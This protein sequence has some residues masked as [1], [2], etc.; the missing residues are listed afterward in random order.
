MNTLN[1]S[2]EHQSLPR[3]IAITGQEGSG[4]DSLGDFFAN[5]GYMHVSAGDVLRERARGLGHADPIPRT[6][7][8]QVGD[9]LKKEFG[10]SP[11]TESTLAKYE[12]SREEFPAGL[13]ISGLRRVG[14]LKAFK[15]HGA[16]SIWIDADEE[17]RF[18]HINNRSRGDEQAR[19]DFA[20]KSKEE[21]YGAT[22][23]GEDGV[24]L[25]A[26]ELL[27]DCQVA[28]KGKLSE[29]YQNAANALTQ[30]AK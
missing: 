15:A 17:Q 8:S 1:P 25:Q 4:K 5:A 26:I 21:Y 7:L 20:A 6:I 22:Q 2:V 27:A 19:E 28:N 24:N 23:G 29:L 9:E 3:L 10:P 18:G 30:L 13:V 14:E 11:I 16:V 12:Q